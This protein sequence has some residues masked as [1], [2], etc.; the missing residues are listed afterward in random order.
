MDSSQDALWCDFQL[1]ISS[2]VACT[3]D[4]VLRSAGL[5][6]EGQSGCWAY[7]VCDGAAILGRSVGPFASRHKTGPA[8]TPCV[9]SPPRM[10]RRAE[11]LG[12][13]S[14]ARSATCPAQAA[15]AGSVGASEA[16]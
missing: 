12:K 3:D 9:N 13:R 7:I 5:L 4:P 16:A 6:I 1:R 11:A 15:F 10:R 2:A 8:L 14:I